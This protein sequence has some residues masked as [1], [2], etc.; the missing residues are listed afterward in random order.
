MGGIGA[1]LVAYTVKNLPAMRETWDPKGKSRY[2]SIL[3]WKVRGQRSLAGYSPWVI[4]S[5][6]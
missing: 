4:K 1:S 6:T 5:Q 3:T 2:S